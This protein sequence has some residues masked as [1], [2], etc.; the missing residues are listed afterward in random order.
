MMLRPSLLFGLVSAHS[1]CGICG[2]KVKSDI[3][4]FMLAVEIALK[5]GETG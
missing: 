3:E 5:Y 4:K 2:L 1:I